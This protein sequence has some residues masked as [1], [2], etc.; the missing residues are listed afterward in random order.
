MYAPKIANIFD[1]IQHHSRLGLENNSWKTNQAAFFCVRQ[2]YFA[3]SCQQIWGCVNQPLILFIHHIWGETVL[4]IIQ[5][6]DRMRYF[7][8]FQDL[9][10]SVNIQDD[11]SWAFSETVQKNFQNHP[12]GQLV[13]I[14]SASCQCGRVFELTLI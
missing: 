4:F 5:S 2:V 3:N 9:F 7:T 12:Y 13:L 10:N 11:Q 14:S 8:T 1:H 6:S